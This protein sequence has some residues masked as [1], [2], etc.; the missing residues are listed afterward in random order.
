MCVSGGNEGPQHEPD[1]WSPAIRE[2]VIWRRTQPRAS[3]RTTPPPPQKGVS[4][5]P[6]LVDPQEAAA[7]VV[8]DGKVKHL[9]GG[10]RDEV[11]GVGLW[12]GVHSLSSGQHRSRCLHTPHLVLNGQLLV[13]RVAPADANRRE[14][15]AAAAGRRWSASASGPVTCGRTSSCR[16]ENTLPRE[17]GAAGL[18]PHP[19]PGSARRSPSRALCYVKV[20]QAADPS[21]PRA[22]Q[23]H[24]RAR[25]LAAGFGELEVLAAL[26]GAGGRGGGGGELDGGACG[27][28]RRG[29]RRRRRATRSPSGAD[30]PHQARKRPCPFLRQSGRAAHRVGAQVGI[31]DL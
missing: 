24:R 17:M 11:A 13:A 18:H 22:G 19:P 30:R 14:R 12:S 16:P 4:P 31:D 25:P 10:V 3:E 7:L 21:D 28:G 8:A 5:D 15:E 2:A 29:G 6:R 9:G 20:K 1:W 23:Q 27:R 26:R